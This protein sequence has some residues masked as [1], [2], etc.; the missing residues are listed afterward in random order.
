[1]YYGTKRFFT[2]PQY[3]TTQS[4]YDPVILKRTPPSLTSI[5]CT[6]ILYSNICLDLQM[7]IFCS[8]FQTR[9]VHRSVASHA[10]PTCCTSHPPWFVFT[11]KIQVFQNVTQ[12]HFQERQLDPGNEQATT[13]KMTQCTFTADLILQQHPWKNSNLAS[14]YKTSNY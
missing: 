9:F 14:N 5:T 4:Y 12:C 10:Y 13:F 2:F 7:R 1:M 8:A 6:L 3:F 11:M